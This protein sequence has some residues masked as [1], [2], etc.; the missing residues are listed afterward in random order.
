[1][2][3][4]LG[5]RTPED[6][7]VETDDILE[8]EVYGLL[9]WDRQPLTSAVVRLQDTQRFAIFRDNFAANSADAVTDPVGWSD[10]ELTGRKLLDEDLAIGTISEALDAVRESH[11]VAVADSPDLHHLHEGSIHAYIRCVKYDPRLTG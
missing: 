3:S 4:G 7:G 2:V 11:D 9:L 8:F 6:L 5:V 10:E 1:M